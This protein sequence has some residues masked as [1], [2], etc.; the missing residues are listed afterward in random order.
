[1]IWREIHSAVGF[2]VTPNETH[3]RRPVAQNHKAIE[4]PER[5]RRQ[6]EE[7]DCRDAIDMIGHKGP[8]PVDAENSVRKFRNVWE[9]AVY[10]EP[11][12]Q[13][14]WMPTPRRV[15]ATRR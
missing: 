14:Y 10:C 2:V 12:P 4:Q 9:R 1:V 5:N 13:P 8:P 6:H 3:G 15:P 7:I 11:W